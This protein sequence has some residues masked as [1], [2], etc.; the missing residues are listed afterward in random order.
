LYA[1]LQRL[2]C[3]ENGNTN[4]V[5]DMPDFGKLALQQTS[6]DTL[7]I[8]L[9][10]SWTLG[11]DLPSLQEVQ[12][13]LEAAPANRQVAMDATQLTEWDSGFLTFLMNLYQYCTQNQIQLDSSHLPEGARQLIALATA[14]PEKKDARKTSKRKIFLAQVGEDTL[15][16]FR[17][18]IE[19]LSFIG[20]ATLAFLKLLRGKA[21]YQKSELWLTMEACGG[22]ALS[23]VTLISFLIGLILAFIGAIQLKLFGAELYVAN[24]VGVAMVRLMASIFTIGNNSVFLDASQRTMSATGNPKQLS[25][26][27]KDPVLRQFLTRG[28]QS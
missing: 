23:I 13:K 8:S 18:I 2:K 26:E 12:Q 7:T 17:S 16:F 9:I 6:G 4:K 1:L 28:E 24:L 21:Q 11:K 20:E 25:A 22:R 10:G 27:T 19:L 14:V 15:H 5:N 3:I